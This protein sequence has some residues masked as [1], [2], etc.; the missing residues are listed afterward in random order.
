MTSSF[1]VDNYLDSVNSEAEPLKRCK[2]L[3][4]LLSYGGFRLKKWLFSNRTVL[5]SVASNVRMVPT[6]DLD[7]DDL[8]VEKKTLGVHW[9][10][11]KAEMFHN[12]RS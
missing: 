6:L 12:L 5:A 11:E 2:G 4:S 10:C 1:Y 3:S 9:D 7:L 8:P